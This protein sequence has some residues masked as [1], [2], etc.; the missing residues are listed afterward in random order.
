MIA[1]S[2]DDIFT[3]PRRYSLYAAE[4]G[5]FHF[6]HRLKED[7]YGVAAQRGAQQKRDGPE[8]PPFCIK[9]IC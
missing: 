8:G 6:F 4:M 1:N 2:S 9:T 7:V 3:F 5:F